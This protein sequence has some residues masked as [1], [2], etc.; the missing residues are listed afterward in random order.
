MLMC[1]LITI[2]LSLDITILEIYVFTDI[3]IVWI[4]MHSDDIS[5]LGY[6]ILGYQITCIY[7]TRDITL[8]TCYII[9]EHN[10]T[11]MYVTRISLFV[12]R[13]FYKILYFLYFN[14]YILTIQLFYLVIYIR[15]YFIFVH[16]SSW[17]RVENKLHLIGSQN[18]CLS[19]FSLYNNILFCETFYFQMQI[20]QQN[21]KSD[22]SSQSLISKNG[23]EMKN[24]ITREKSYSMKKC[25]NIYLRRV[26]EVILCWCIE[27]LYIC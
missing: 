15:C 26:H 7:A 18:S 10:C 17:L 5:V 2:S 14:S 27:T 24:F 13:T 23:T 20:L 12:V 25:V 9:L 22:F 4:H 6:I 11:W 8:L 21:V 3:T 1:T 19:V 16:K